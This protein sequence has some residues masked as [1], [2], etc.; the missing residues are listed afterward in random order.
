MKTCKACKKETPGAK[1]RN[2]ELNGRRFSLCADCGRI[3]FLNEK[4]EKV[5]GLLQAANPPVRASHKGKVVTF[6]AEK[7]LAKG[8][9]LSNPEATGLPVA[10]FRLPS[11]F[12]VDSVR[13]LIVVETVPSPAPKAD[14]EGKTKP[15]R[16]RHR[17]RTVGYSIRV[18]PA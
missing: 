11:R 10:S 8:Q 3:Q 5:V 9:M 12:E 2:V 14:A 6:H 18:L 17:R 15:Q 1:Q 13:P 7:P 16:P 4:G